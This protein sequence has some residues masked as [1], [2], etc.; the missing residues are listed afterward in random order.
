MRRMNKESAPIRTY[1]E[2][3]VQPG[4]AEGLAEFFDRCN[5]LRTSAAQ[6]GCRSAELTISSDGEVAVV[7]AVWDDA[8]AY[9]R[10]V[11]RADRADDADELS[12]F[13]KQPISA[14]TVGRVFGIVLDGSS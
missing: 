8:A 7:T 5:I 1:L 14:K 13:L 4:A 2:L 9:E 6:S 3:E 12:S 10:W 11:S